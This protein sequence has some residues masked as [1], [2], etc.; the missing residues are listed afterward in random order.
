MIGKA[1]AKESK[2]TFFSISASTL[3]SKWVGEG[4]KMVRTLFALATIHQPSI[5]FIDEIDS[6]LCKRNEGDQESSRRI[7]TEFMVQLGGTRSEEGDK[8]LI[9][10]AT[11]RPDELDEAVK[12]RLEKRLY[13][14]LPNL[15]GR[16]QF[17]TNMLRS[18]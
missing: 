8:I 16:A 5:V 18:E 10:G 2:S 12:R 4:E 6:L 3:T 14:P 9:I 15:E 13:I 7:K 17:I 11:N 1:I